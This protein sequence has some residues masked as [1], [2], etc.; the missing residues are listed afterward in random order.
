MIHDP[1][2]GPLLILSL[3]GNRVEVLRN[4]AFAKPPLKAFQAE[5][6]WRFLRGSAILDRVQEKQQTRIP[7]LR[8]QLFFPI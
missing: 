8:R 1:H 3:G 2:F 5:Q 4:V 7:G 6:L